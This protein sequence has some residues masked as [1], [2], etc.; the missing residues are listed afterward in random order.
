MHLFPHCPFSSC[1]PSMLLCDYLTLFWILLCLLQLKRPLQLLLSGQF[2]LLFLLMQNIFNLS[3]QF[4]LPKLY[5]LCRFLDL[6]LDIISAILF[7][8]LFLPLRSFILALPLLPVPLLSS[9]HLFPPP[10]AFTPTT[11]SS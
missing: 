5:P 10:S 8:L 11:S 6:L 2:L 7:L 4:H 9:L 1:L 3:T